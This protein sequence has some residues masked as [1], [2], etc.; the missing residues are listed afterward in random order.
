MDFDI[1]I[2]DVLYKTANTYTITQQAGSISSSSLDVLV[3]D[4]DIPTAMMSVQILDE[5]A[6][7]FFYGFIQSVTSPEFST[8]KE[9]HRY[10]IDVLSAE[11]IFN[12]RYVT[13][14]YSSATTNSIV[15]D[16]FTNYISTEGITLG[17]I[18]TGGRNYNT[19]NFQFTKLY[20]LLSELAEDAKW[21]F[22]IS[23]D[24]KFYFVDNLE[25]VATDLPD[26]ITN[27]KKDE[28][29]GDLRSVQIITGASAETSNQTEN[30]V[31]ITNQVTMV[32]GY[33]LSDVTGSGLGITINAS[34]A[35]VGVRGIDDGDASIT[36][37]Y[38]V[39]SNT[40]TVNSAATTKPAATDNVVIV[41]KGFFEI[42]ITNTND[43]LVSQISDLN[44]TT[45]IIEKL[46]TD[47][48]IDNFDDADNRANSLLDQYNET[49][50]EISCT[51]LD[52]DKS[53]LFNQWTF[54]YIDL[55]ITGDYVIIER[56][57]SDFLESPLI[58]IKLKNK[59][60]YKRYGETFRKISKQ[61]G[62][63]VEVFKQSSIGDSMINNENWVI[64]HSGIIFFPVASGAV[65]PL[66]D[67][68]S[69]YA[70]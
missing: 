28:E 19:Y 41:Y 29:I 52:L 64:M 35:T 26:K 3:E 39:G 67:T 38:E 65:E 14:T 46:Y 10:R 40:V 48:T 8:S 2:N 1:K 57:I 66:P 36:F 32:L 7:P 45:G 22:Y 50:S 25:F 51:C 13:E 17:K 31:W 53:A 11:V 56:T 34:P 63:D 33:N 24:K 23:A 70:V 4:Q 9:I 43:Q 49:E 55:G 27:L 30:F 47:E 37:L 5:S 12:N 61:V 69:F 15:S 42:A 59:N 68:E 16:L 58:R 20:D 54:N 18:S 60:Y 62:K 44:G 21:T 6:T